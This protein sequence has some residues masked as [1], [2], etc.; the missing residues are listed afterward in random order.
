MRLPGLMLDAGQRRA[1]REDRSLKRMRPS[2]GKVPVT[3][4]W[5]KLESAVREQGREVVPNCLITAPRGGIDLSLLNPEG[6]PVE[7]TTTIM[8]LPEF[9]L[10]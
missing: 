4:N 7:L 8:G 9:Q 2:W 5:R 3:T 1:M 10:V 6:S